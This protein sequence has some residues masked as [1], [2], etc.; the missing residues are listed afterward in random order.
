[1]PSR[2]APRKWRLV[3]GNCFDALAKLEPNSVDA[4]ITDPP[5]GI[6]VSGLEWDRPAH[7][8][9]GG[10][11]RRR[12]PTENPNTRLQR[13]SREWSAACLHSLKPGGHILAFAAAR[14]SH[15]LT[16]G[17]EEAG[18]EIRDALMWLQGQGYPATRPLRD[19][20][21]TGLKPAWEPIILAR[22]PLEGSL[23][24]TLAA[25]GT[26][27]MN[28][29]ACRIELTARD[30]PSEGRSH[31]RRLTASQRGRWPANLLLSHGCC[32][33]KQ[34]EADCPIRLLGER[35]RFFYCAKA[36]RREREAGCEQ[37]PRRVVQTFKI[38]AH[39]EQMCAANPVANVHPTVK[40]IDL[41]R[42]LVRLVTPAGGLVLDPF[43]GSGSTGA[44]AVLEGARFIGI[45]REAAYVPIARA[46]IRHWAQPAK[47][48]RER[49][50][51]C[52]GE[53]ATCSAARR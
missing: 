25:H 1:M 22:K 44:A 2:T 35:H 18:L 50:R 5:Y 10:R 53:P 20:L 36:P 37:L 21:G 27:A 43:A 15:R 32:T 45:E 51:G 29:D 23:D 4:V 12:P 19:G 7:F 39:Q 28:I 13:F 31:G 11:K 6:G 34:C 48:R 30:C 46:R 47:P 3:E 49:R 26:G 42:W 9:P 14:T 52:T 17:L 40:P 41:M 8:N 33:D 38:G 16:C 24:Q